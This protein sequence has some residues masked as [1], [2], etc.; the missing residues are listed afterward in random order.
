M[1][2][3]VLLAPGQAGGPLRP[4]PSSSMGGS[5]SDK[6]AQSLRVRACVCVCVTGAV[7]RPWRAQRALLSSRLKRTPPAAAP[8][9]CFHYGRLCPVPRGTHT[10]TE[11]GKFISLPRHLAIRPDRFHYNQW[12]NS[13]VDF[14]GSDL[15]SNLQCGHNSFSLS[16]HMDQ[17]RGKRC[18]SEPTAAFTA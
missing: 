15:V 5:K 7:E 3:A 11:R 12:S 2:D 8:F 9:L 6:E 1:A 13:Y 10:N 14:N 4:G 16:T 17:K 18:Q